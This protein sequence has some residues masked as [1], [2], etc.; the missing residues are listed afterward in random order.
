MCCLWE[1]YKNYDKNKHWKRGAGNKT[2]HKGFFAFCVF[3]LFERGKANNLGFG[4]WGN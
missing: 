4:L 1:G 3:W 2:K